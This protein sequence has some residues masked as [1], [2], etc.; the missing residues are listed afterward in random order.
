MR[1]LLERVGAGTTAARPSDASQVSN[2]ALTVSTIRSLELPLDLERPLWAAMNTTL[3]LS[4]SSFQ[5]SL[6]VLINYTDDDLP[7]YSS[8]AGRTG[9]GGSWPPATAA[10]S[11]PFTG[12]SPNFVRPPEGATPTPLRDYR[13]SVILPTC[14]VVLDVGSSGDNPYPFQAVD[15]DV[16]VDE[17]PLGFPD[18]SNGVMAGPSPGAPPIPWNIGRV[19]AGALIDITVRSTTPDG[20]PFA[21]IY[22]NPFGIGDRCN[23]PGCVA[24]VEHRL[25]AYCDL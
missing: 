3:V 23:A 2:K 21:G 12:P 11:P 5:G 19:R 13:G 25:N 9:S 17:V 22:V 1:D 24:H 20:R 7:A 14:V 6:E 8:G 10:N 16:L 4:E 15:A 18:G